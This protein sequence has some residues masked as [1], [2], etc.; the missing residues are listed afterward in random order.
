MVRETNRYA[1]QTIG[2]A[3]LS[4]HS[5]LRKWKEVSAREIEI[6][7]GIIFWMG[8][9][10]MP[11]LTDY[12][13]KK[14]MFENK[15]KSFMSRN[16]FELILRMW[17]L[18]NNQECPKG[19]R[20]FKI[21]GLIDMLL[22][23]FQ[24]ANIPFR[25]VCID[26]SI[27]PFRGKL[28]FKQYIKN[29]KNKFGIKLYKLCTS[30]GYT[31]N[32]KVYCGRDAQPGVPVASSVVLDLSKDLLDSGRIIYTDNFYTSVSLAHEL[33]KRSTH[34]VG[35]LRSNRKLNP[36][37]VI[38]AKLK[39]SE[40]IARESNTGVIVLKWKD[41]RDVLVLSTL[42][43]DRMVDVETENGKVVRKP[44]II[45]DYNNSKGFIDISDQMK[46][47]SAALRRGVKWY[48]KLAIELI[49]GTSLVNAHI[50]YKTVTGKN[51]NIT[52]FKE[53]VTMGLLGEETRNNDPATMKECSLKNM[54]PQRR[55]CV[56]CYE[57]LKAEFDRKQASLKAKQTPYKCEKCDSFYCVECFFIRHK[58][59]R[60]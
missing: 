44:Q 7:L 14:L 16:R 53:E 29:K 49:T 39:T 4:R 12:W 13:S 60:L 58:S 26:E 40:T 15:V 27:V 25:D 2:N 11:R 28:S 42:H 23:R 56:V 20:L 57:K 21:Q 41:K 22:E 18:S 52:Q 5:R 36:L 32:L 10:K 19:D 6:F 50:I 37:D 47:Y 55:R 8:L 35:T 38:H 46:A 9:N 34:L 1:Q 48:R 31:N 3:N 43:D 17:H 30:K 33:A 45:L 51:T 59:T 24:K 54:G